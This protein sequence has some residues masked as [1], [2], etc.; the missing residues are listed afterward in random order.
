MDGTSERG[1][2]GEEGENRGKV[3]GQWQGRK[4]KSLNCNCNC[5]IEK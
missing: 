3:V 4:V 5:N 2:R 1:R